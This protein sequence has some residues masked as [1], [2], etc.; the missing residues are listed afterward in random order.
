MVAQLEAGALD[1]AMTP[2]LPDFARLS[3]DP[4]LPGRLFPNAPNFYM[5]QANCDPQ[6]ARRQAGAP[7]VRLH[8]RPQ[9]HARH[10]AARASGT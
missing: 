8:A 5:I 10:G 4:Q 2:G 9:A 6:A 7:G 1:L 3:N